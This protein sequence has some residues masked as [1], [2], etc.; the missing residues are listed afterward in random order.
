MAHKLLRFQPTEDRREGWCARITELVA[1]TNKDPA[2][3]G[4]QGAGEP[5]PVVG[6][7]APGA[8]KG[9]AA[10][11]KKA[12]S[13]ATSSPCGEPSC[14]IVQR[15]L[16]DAR[17]SLERRQE[18]MTAPS[19]TSAILARTSR[20]PGSSSTTLGASLSLASS[21]TWSSLTSLG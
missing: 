3:G 20:F 2:M 10:Q 4:P 9:K 8:R 17:I 16:E 18:I 11:A 6:H 19:T 13:R 12:V 5:D 21:A 14:Q 15:A 7:H 1:I